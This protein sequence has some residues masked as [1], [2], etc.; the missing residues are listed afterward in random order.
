[1]Q[2]GLSAPRAFEIATQ[3][4]GR[5]DQLQGEFNKSRRTAASRLMF[6]FCAIC[7]GTALWFS[8]YTFLLLG[9]TT[10]QQV[11]AFA[12][13]TVSLLIACGWRFAIPVI[14][15]VEIEWKRKVLGAACIALGFAIS[16]LFC[17]GIFPSIAPGLDDSPAGA[18]PIFLWAAFFPIACFAP[19]G[20]ALMMSA[21]DRAHW[22][23][24]KTH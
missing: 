4:I 20:L 21:E 17:H 23:M 11:A 18:I 7:V 12:A 22:G 5:P 1:M 9:M 19:L 10:I 16:G 3:A 24:K 8:G 14:P 6:V 2:S 13:V 15:V